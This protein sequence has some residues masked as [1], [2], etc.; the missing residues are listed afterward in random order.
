MALHT[1]LEWG[2]QEHLFEALPRPKVYLRPTGVVKIK[3]ATVLR[4]VDTT[5]W[6]LSS[7]RTHHSATEDLW[8]H[9][10]IEHD[11]MQS[12]NFSTHPQCTA[13]VLYL[14][15]T[16]F[17]S[18]KT[19]MECRALP[20]VELPLQC[21]VERSSGHMSGYLVPSIAFLEADTHAKSRPSGAC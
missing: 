14:G 21:S 19:V 6:H 15:V 3:V 16:L 9:W 1:L 8:G 18:R 12:Q 11:S 10:R 13:I 20:K 4:Q 17:A 2:L 5:K 7:H